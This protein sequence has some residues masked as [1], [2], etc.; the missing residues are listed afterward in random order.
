MTISALMGLSRIQDQWNVIEKSSLVRLDLVLDTTRK[1]GRGVHAFKN[2]VL[3]GQD[4]EFKALKELEAIEEI[5]RQYEVLPISPEEKKHLDALRTG[6]AKY[7]VAVQKVANLRR[8]GAEIGA[9][10][11]AVSGVDRPV[12][13]AIEELRKAIIKDVAEN[14]AAFRERIEDNKKTLLIGLIVTACFGLLFGYFLVR[15]IKSGLAVANATLDSVAKGDFSKEIDSSRRDEIGQLVNRAAD[16][17]SMLKGFIAAQLAMARAHNEEGRTSEEMRAADFPGAYGDMARNLNAMVKGHIGVQTQFVD[18]MVDYAG[19]KFETRMAP[20]PGE[21]KAISDTAERLHGVLFK[22]QNNAME[23]LKIKIALDN[24]SSCVMMADAE[25]IIRYQNKACEALMRGSEA[26]FRSSMPGFSAA[27]VI[28]SSFDQFHKNASRQRNILAGLRGEHRATIE[29][30]GLHMRAI[31]NSIAD[32]TGGRLGTVIEW[33]DR[34][35]E[36]N[37]EKEIGGIVQAAA[38]GDFTKRIEETGKSGFFLEIANGLNAILATSEQALGEISRILKAMEQGDLAQTI[39]ANFQGVFAELK[40]NSNGTI[41]RLREIIAQIRAASATINTA[42]REIATGNNDLSRRTEEQASSLEETA[43]S[44]EEFASS[45]R[46]NAENAQEAN[47]LA[48]VAADAAQRGGEVVSQVVTTMS[49]ITESNREIADITTL[50]D[51]I[52]FQTNSAC[53]Q[54]GR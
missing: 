26:N 43:A 23:T 35:A 8:E 25:G 50:I 49:A 54:R 7:K 19:G 20:L 6:V 17:T 27:S 5:A 30:G 15:S 1:F 2:V 53:A 32:E 22:A 14:S 44:L 12:E 41:E 39:E 4:Y 45:V 18:L 34:T 16:M 46:Q 40:G 10:D 37:A 3:R 38:S 28:G 24:S 48:A 52:A 31:A 36:V 11:N 33:L 47:R 42:A 9:I 21:R 29:V 51:G 13:D